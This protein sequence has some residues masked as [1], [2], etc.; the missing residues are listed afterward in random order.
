MCCWKYY[1]Y[2]KARWTGRL[3][4]LVH[5]MSHQESFKGLTSYAVHVDFLNYHPPA[6]SKNHL[7]F[8]SF[9]INLLNNLPQG[10]VLP[11]LEDYSTFATF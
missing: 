10:K 11:H 9:S 2:L 1:V 4:N 5:Q 7:C 6:S 3:Q 8:V